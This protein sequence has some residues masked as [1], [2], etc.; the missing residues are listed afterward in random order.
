M[1]VYRVGIVVL[2]LAEPVP[3]QE[4]AIVRWIMCQLHRR[5]VP[6]AIY[7]D[8]LAFV[9]GVGV[10]PG[11][12]QGHHATLFYPLPCAVQ[13][14]PGDFIVLNDFKKAEGAEANSVVIV[15]PVVYGC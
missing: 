11:A 8:A 9:S 10:F 4:L 1:T 3:L 14:R 5:R 7:Q 2:G 13:Q 12:A 15:E 6:E